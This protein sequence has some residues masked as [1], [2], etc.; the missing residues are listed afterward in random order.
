V[1]AIFAAMDTEVHPWLAPA[2]V[3]ET[4]ELSGFQVRSVDYGGV[5]AVVCRTGIGRRAEAAAAAVFDSG[6]FAVAISFGTAGGISPSLR[7]GDIMLCDPV[8][9]SADCGY[10]DEDGSLAAHDGLIEATRTELEASGIPLLTGTSLTVDRGV[11]TGAEK[12]RLHESYGHDVVEM[13]SYW[14]G[15]AAAQRGVPFLTVRIVTDEAADSL[16]DTA[17]VGPDG[18]I[19]YDVLASWARE[20]PQEVAMLAKM[21]ERWRLGASA[22]AQFADA[23]LRPS[24]LSAIVAV[25]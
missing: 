8:C 16:L 18:T 1:I 24:V 11:L 20:H 12:R 22:M 10:C 19:D 23:F 21:Y 17:F 25:R 13:E 3:R 14:V 9:V 4:S 15:K 5:N 6:R 7:A 2:S